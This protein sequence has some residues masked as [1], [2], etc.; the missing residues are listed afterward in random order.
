[1]R[2]FTEPQPVAFP[3]SPPNTSARRSRRLVEGYRS[4]SNP[5]SRSRTT[6][7]FCRRQKDVSAPRANAQGFAP[8]AL[9]RAGFGP[10]RS[11]RPIRPIGR[12]AGL[13]PQPVQILHGRIPARARR[14]PAMVRPGA[15]YAGKRRYEDLGADHFD[16]RDKSKAI[17]RLVKRLNDLGCEVE[18]RNVA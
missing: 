12:A 6:S 18:V 13:F 17:S 3:S 8:T 2:F 14:V 9:G 10:I 4:A 11:I 1:M 5:S 15:P 16:R 7:I